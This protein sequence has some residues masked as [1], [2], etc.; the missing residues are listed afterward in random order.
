MFV[1]VHMRVYEMGTLGVWG[2]LVSHKR[3]LTHH[4]SS[5]GWASRLPLLYVCL[6][7]IWLGRLL[8]LFFFLLPLKLVCYAHV[9]PCT[10]AFGYFLYVIY[11][12]YIF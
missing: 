8:H 5:Q 2:E 9:F 6:S 12:G 3:S 1:C 7:G 11:Y 10:N 4:S